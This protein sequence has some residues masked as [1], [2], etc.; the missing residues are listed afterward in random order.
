MT[1]RQHILVLTADAGFG[2][3]SAAKAVVD[4]ILDT[5]ADECDCEILNPADDLR[6]PGVIRRPQV[7]Y[8]RTIRSGRGVYYLSYRMSDSLPIST[9][10]ESVISRL[11]APVFR[12]LLLEQRPDAIISTYLLYNSALR[13][14]LKAN[15]MHTPF[16]SVI[17]D[18]ADV[19]HLWF[20][21]G[22]DLFFTASDEVRKQA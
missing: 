15:R 11:M 17:T 5:H 16:F 8:D 20:Q 6:T 7:N 18:M 19:H 21:P 9:V 12:D 3:R 10:V 2:H 22:P 4:A 13:S 14:A 1:P